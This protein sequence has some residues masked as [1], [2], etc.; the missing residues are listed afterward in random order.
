MG[1]IELYLAH[2]GLPAVTYKKKVFFSKINHF[3]EPVL[4]LSELLFR[5]TLVVG[6]NNLTG[7]EARLQRWDPGGG[8]PPRGVQIRWCHG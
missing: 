7:T 1:K 8:A 2:S 3:Y 4:R 6:E 5:D